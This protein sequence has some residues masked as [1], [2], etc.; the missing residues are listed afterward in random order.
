MEGRVWYFCHICDH[1]SG[2]GCLIESEEFQVQRVNR[3]YCSI[4]QIHGRSLEI[5][6]KHVVINGQW[7]RR[8][9]RDLNNVLSEIRR[10]KDAKDLLDG[11]KE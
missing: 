6:K 2:N 3:E 4:S 1:Y 10:I 11:G 9:S 5:R 8:E 7:F